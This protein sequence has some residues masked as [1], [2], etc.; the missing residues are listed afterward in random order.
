[1]KFLGHNI[2]MRLRYET[3]PATIAQ[4]IVLGF[5]NIANTINS[6]IA[7]C[8]H[9]SGSDCATNALSSFAYYILI[10][11]WFGIIVALGTLAQVRRNRRLA[12][13]LILAEIA[14]F[15]V[16]G[17]NIKLGIS[18]HN[19]ALGLITSFVDLVLAFWVI[20]LA[21]RL[22]KAGSGRVPARRQ[23]HNTD[24]H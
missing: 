18:Y 11:I 21:Y 6:I 7:T 13:L 19:G 22:L 17:Y 20:S 5:L 15:L 4:F 16:A 14:V 9:G 12:Q 10:M 1:M 2:Y 8:R 23:P 24:N 3:G